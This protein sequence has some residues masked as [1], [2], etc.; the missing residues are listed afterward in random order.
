MV[1][2]SSRLSFADRPSETWPITERAKASDARFWRRTGR[3]SSGHLF[4]KGESWFLRYRETVI[5]DDGSIRVQR[6][7]RIASATGTT[8]SKGA[9]R[10]IANE[11]LG[12]NREGRLR[13]F[14]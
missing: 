1:G 11:F 3:Q 8:R 12:L 14:P 4:K 9:A 2:Q 10:A 5:G 6:C 7:R 13:I